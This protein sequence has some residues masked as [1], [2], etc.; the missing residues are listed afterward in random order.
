MEQLVGTYT[1][2]TIWLADGKLYVKREGRARANLLPVSRNLYFSFSS[3]GAMA[4]FIFDGNK[5]LGYRVDVYDPPSQTWVPGE[6][7]IER[8]D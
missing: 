8:I 5:P 4:Y 7:L 2:R 3:V 1:Q 6:D